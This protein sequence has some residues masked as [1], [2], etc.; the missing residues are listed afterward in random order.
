ME[1]QEQTLPIAHG[2]WLIF[3][4]PEFGPLPALCL[5]RLF[6]SNRS[7]LQADSQK[8]GIGAPASDD[9]GQQMGSHIPG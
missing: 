9:I 7:R 8:P 3:Y 2:H 6:A 4:R 5:V 1:S